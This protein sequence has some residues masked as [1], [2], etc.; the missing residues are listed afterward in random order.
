VAQY[1]ALRDKVDLRKWPTSENQRPEDANTPL[2]KAHYAF[3]ARA[4]F[5]LA[6][7]HGQ[8]FLPKLFREIGQTSRKQ[9][10]MRTVEKAYKKLAGE[11]LSALLAAA[12]APVAAPANAARTP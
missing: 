2:T 8:D 3:A 12:M 11:D 9:A 4:V 5:L 7:R 6:E 1:A 10:D